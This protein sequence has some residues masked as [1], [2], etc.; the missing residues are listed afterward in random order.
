M[1]WQHLPIFLRILKFPCILHKGLSENVVGKN[2]FLPYCN[3]NM[4]G[5]NIFE[6][7]VDVP[8][9][10]ASGHF[11]SAAHHHFHKHIPPSSEEADLLLPFC[12]G[13]NTLHDK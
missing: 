3:V 13:S 7:S 4:L 11:V 8:L 6:T 10:T 9:S 1:Q 12:Y 2:L 5:K